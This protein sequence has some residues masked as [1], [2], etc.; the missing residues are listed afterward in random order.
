MVV[1]MRAN[2]SKSGKRRSH[3]ALSGMRMAACVCGALRRPHRACASCGT[4][5][6]RVVVDVVARAE[7]GVRRT[8]RKQKELRASGQAAENKEKEPQTQ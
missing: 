4:Y 6:E 8:K 2:R 3:H 7:R 5:R 1:R